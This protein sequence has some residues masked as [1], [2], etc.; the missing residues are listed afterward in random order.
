M[1]KCPIFSGGQRQLICFGRALIRQS[2]LL[3]LDEIS[4]AMDSEVTKN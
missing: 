4:S 3:I 2:K 1:N